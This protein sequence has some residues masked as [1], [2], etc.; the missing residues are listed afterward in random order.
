MWME[1]FGVTSVVLA[2]CLV[3][4]YKKY[5][6]SELRRALFIL[7]GTSFLWSGCIFLYLLYEPFRVF[8]FD[9]S[10]VCGLTTVVAWHIFV[11]AY[12]GMNYHKKLGFKVSSVVF[13]LSLSFVKLTNSFHG[14]Y[15]EVTSVSP[16]IVELKP[17][18]WIIYGVSYGSIG[19]GAVLL[20]ERAFGLKRWKRIIVILSSLFLPAVVSPLVVS[21]TVPRISG[22]EPIGV[23]LFGLIVVSSLRRDFVSG[24]IQLANVQMNSKTFEIVS[25]SSGNVHGYSKEA[26][27]RISGLKKGVAIQDILPFDTA[28]SP[29]IVV[30]N[31]RR[32]LHRK[33]EYDDLSWHL[34]TSFTGNETQPTQKLTSQQA[35]T[36][37]NLSDA[38]AHELRNPL[39]ITRGWVETA[40]DNTSDKETLEDALRRAQEATERSEE[41][42]SDIIV[43]LSSISSTDNESWH[44]SRNLWDNVRSGA[45]TEVFCDRR[46]IETINNY[47]ETRDLEYTV[48]VGDDSIEYVFPELSSDCEKLFEFGTEE[49]EGV[50]M[51]SIRAIVENAGW[52]VSAENKNDGVRLLFRNVTVRGKVSS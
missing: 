32:Y 38:L 25:D 30:L 28:D 29:S 43:L 37:S 34:L 7:F 16:L 3:M 15:F 2:Y 11:S 24:S 19:V 47:L 4:T 49:D 44:E 22:I 23:A 27:E 5:N 48:T 8:L 52:S 18:F 40:R 39:T 50:I 41:I 33:V 35:E 9:V 36:I 13:L 45:E 17:M 46:N 6:K 42:V 31:G 20:F 21:Q 51:P 12:N 26:A 14:L 1:L 10:L